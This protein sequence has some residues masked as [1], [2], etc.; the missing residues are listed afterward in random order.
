MNTL[1]HS[2]A[3][4]NLSTRL[5]RRRNLEFGLNWRRSLAAGIRLLPAP[6]TTQPTRRTPGT[7]LPGTGSEQTQ[8]A[9]DRPQGL[10][11]KAQFESGWKIMQ[12]TS[13]AMCHGVRGDLMRTFAPQP[14][15]R[16]A[17]ASHSGLVV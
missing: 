3:A 5:P 10:G 17:S 16:H 4:A 11:G 7:R 6:G 1:R 8:P 9:R 2:S 15:A 14:G 13:Q 12:R